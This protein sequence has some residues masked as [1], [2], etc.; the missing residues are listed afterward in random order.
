MVL[1][2]N[3]PRGSLDRLSFLYKENEKRASFARE[4]KSQQVSDKKRIRLEKNRE[5]ARLSRRR[6]KQYQQMLDAKASEL[7]TELLDA[8]QKH[9][10][11]IEESYYG[12]IDAALAA[13]RTAKTAVTSTGIV[14][15]TSTTATPTVTSTTSTPTVTST[16]AT[17]T[18]TSTTSTPTV[19]STTSTPT[20]TQTAS[21]TQNASPTPTVVKSENAPPQPPKGAP[22]AVQRLLQLMDPRSE[23]VAEGEQFLWKELK[24]LVCPFYSRFVFWIMTRVRLARRREA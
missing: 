12:V 4:P 14:A 15:V 20:I 13:H 19:T 5:S 16:T 7:L 9:L 2:T 8:K 24:S 10:R 21:T 11:R 23:E 6:K 1:P 17:P 3:A 22:G 18:V